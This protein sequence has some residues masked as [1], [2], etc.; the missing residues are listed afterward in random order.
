MASWAFRTFERLWSG[1]AE[2][3]TFMQLTCVQLDIGS[4]QP[5]LQ[6]AELCA[7]KYWQLPMPTCVV[8]S[9]ASCQLS[10]SPAEHLASWASRTPAG[11]LASSGL[12]Q[13]LPNYNY[14]L[15]SKPTCTLHT[16]S[17]TFP[18]FSLPAQLMFF[19]AAKLQ[20]CSW[21]LQHCLCCS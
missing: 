5:G 3:L 9:W 20:L 16:H 21:N 8:A 12:C 13:P 4:C 18:Y 19:L 6:L 1:I 17:L 14:A 10:I 2:L 15:Q 7:A 11:Q